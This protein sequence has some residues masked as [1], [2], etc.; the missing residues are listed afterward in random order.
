M[1]VDRKAQGLAAK[2]SSQS[3]GNA[4]RNSARSRVASATKNG[5]LGGTTGNLSDGVSTSTTSRVRMRTPPYQVSDIQLAYAN[6]YLAP[7]ETVG[8]DTITV[9]AAI[10]YNG[11][12]YPFFF[13]GKRDVTIEP[14]GTAT[15]EPLGLELPANATLFVRT[16]V[17]VTSGGKWPIGRFT[18]NALGEGTNGSNG[19][20]TTLSTGSIVA[21]SDQ[22]IFAPCAV[23]GRSESASAATV[24]ILGD[25][26]AAGSG[27]TSGGDSEGRLGF[28]ERALAN[29]LAW[30]SS[31]RSS[32]TFAIFNALHVRRLAHGPQYCSSAIVELGR[33]DLNA[34]ANLA[35]LQSLAQTSW[36]ALSRRG[37]AVYQTTLTPQTT[38]TDSWATV[39]NQTIA[40][41]S[42]EAVRTA[43][44]DWVRTTPA[45]LSGYFEIA[46]IGETT[47][48]SG[49]WKATGSANGYTADGLHPSGSMH[50]LLAAGVAISALR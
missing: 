12:S 31:T 1:A 5:F 50:A 22:T 24:L 6:A 40:S 34:D 49:I 27:E 37:L 14:G 43:F 4:I 19:A 26:I 48:N 38:S 16:Y 35:S 45:P 20:D 11:A 46:D 32:D 3:A 42:R 17:S 13:G 18:R 33:N 41:S 10:E 8:T 15:T 36:Y 7:A 30:I 23:F 28:L 39:G 25:S 44:N 9:R 2:A 29:N 47:R 21:G